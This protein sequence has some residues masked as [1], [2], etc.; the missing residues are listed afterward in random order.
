MW[1]E[2]RINSK[3]LNSIKAAGLIQFLPRTAKGLGTSTKELLTMSSV[4]QLDYVYKYFKPVQGKI[5]DVSDLYLYTFFP[6]AVLQDWDDDHVIE[7]KSLTAAK[8]ARANRGLDLDKNVVIT[9]KEFRTATLKYCP[10]E[11]NAYKNIV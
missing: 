10:K 9:V 5:K 11:I 8:I 7:Y 6:I 2:S 3:A 4:E 1:H